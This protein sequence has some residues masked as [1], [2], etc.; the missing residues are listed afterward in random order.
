MKEYKGLFYNNDYTICKGFVDK[1]T[2]IV[3]LHPDTE[4]IQEKAFWNKNSIE[5]RDKI[6]NFIFA[7]CEKL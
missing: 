5:R 1:E 7:P 2:N 4:L 3:E 6:L